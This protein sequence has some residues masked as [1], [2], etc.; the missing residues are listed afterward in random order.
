MTFCQCYTCS[1]FRCEYLFFSEKI[2][3][4]Q[5][6]EYGFKALPKYQVDQKILYLHISMHSGPYQCENIGTKVIIIQ[7]DML[8]QNFSKYCHRPG[9]SDWM[10]RNK[11]AEPWLLIHL[12]YVR[13]WYEIWDSEN[14]YIVGVYYNYLFNQFQTYEH[15]TGSDSNQVNSGLM[16]D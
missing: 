13:H 14:S 11:I 6:T 15:C 5:H 7:N 2:I 1:F 12:F 8:L 3:P 16:D 10:G 4:K 9:I